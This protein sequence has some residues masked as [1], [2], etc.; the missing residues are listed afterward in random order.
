MEKYLPFPCEGPNKSK[1]CIAKLGAPAPPEFL[2]VEH[3]SGQQLTWVRTASSYLH[4]GPGE[5]V[6]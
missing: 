5:E 3:R 6:F 2:P 4:A 1:M